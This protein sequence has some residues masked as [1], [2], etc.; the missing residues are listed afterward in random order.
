MKTS[1]GQVTVPRHVAIIMDGNGRWARE[2]GLS[3]IDGHKAG[4]KR[5]RETVTACAELGIDYLTLYAFSTENWKRPPGEIRQLMRLLATFLDDRLHDLTEQQIRLL[6]IGDT[7]RLPAYVRSRLQRVIDATCNFDRGTLILA[8][9]YGA[10]AEITSAVKTLAEKVRAGEISPKE[11]S[12]QHIAD[13]LD[14]A[15]IPDPD[16][17]IRTA[18]EQRLSNFLLW[19]ASYAEFWF[20][21][22]K[23]PDFSK[24]NLKEAIAAFSSRKRRF[25]GLEHA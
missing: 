14:T 6:A 23:W 18:N 9:N 10:R 20:T 12:E 4:A 15:G 11:I 22:V 5:V 25:G 7:S 1:S 3:R 13:H 16:L 19:Q 2:R 8:L 21:P 24:E 17:I